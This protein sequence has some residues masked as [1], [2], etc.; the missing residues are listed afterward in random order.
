MFSTEINRRHY[1]SLKLH[2]LFQKYLYTWSIPFK[3]LYTLITSLL[4]PRLNNDFCA[5]VF[6]VRKCSE[7]RD[8]C[9]PLY[10]DHINCLSVKMVLTALQTL[11]PSRYR[12]W[13]DSNTWH[14]SLLPKGK[15]SDVTPSLAPSSLCS[16]TSLCQRS[17][18]TLTPHVP[19]SGDKVSCE[20][21]SLTGG[22]LIMLK[23]SASF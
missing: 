22:T 10:Y 3:H 14:Q 23:N 11:R 12:L 19:S 5:V 4:F 7:P 8:R 17:V 6:Q 18:N 21:A 13:S 9:W 15:I 2:R 20:N 1:F 16:W